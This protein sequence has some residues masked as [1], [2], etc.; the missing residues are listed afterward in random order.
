MLYI[1]WFQIYILKCIDSSL[2]AYGKMLTAVLLGDGFSSYF[3]ILYFQF[4][5]MS[6]ILITGENKKH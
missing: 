4:S 5:A 6:I 3:L 1:V 2:H